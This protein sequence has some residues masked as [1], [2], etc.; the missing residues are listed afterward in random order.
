MLGAICGT[1]LS[2]SCW[3][4]ILAFRSFCCL[5][6]VYWGGEPGEGKGVGG[7]ERVRREGWTGF[8]VGKDI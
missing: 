2:L 4:C 5:F 6:L 7:G 8:S 1:Y 3:R